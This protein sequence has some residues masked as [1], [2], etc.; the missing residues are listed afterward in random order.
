MMQLPNVL[1]FLFGIVQMILYF[2]YKN[3]NKKA[4]MNSKLEE[5]MKQNEGLEDKKFSS[6][7]N[8]KSDVEMGNKV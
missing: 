2:I 7:E 5:A 1:G 4:E 3:A 8:P 6:V